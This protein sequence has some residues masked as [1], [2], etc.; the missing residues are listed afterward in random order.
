MMEITRYVT[1]VDEERDEVQE[2]MYANITNRAPL[3]EIRSMR[4][5][6]N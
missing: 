6:G 1:V 3:L 2:I 4:T 5:E